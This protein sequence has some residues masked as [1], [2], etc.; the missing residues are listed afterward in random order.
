MHKIQG[1]IFVGHKVLHSIVWEELSKFTAQLSRQGFIVRQDERRTV[2]I[3]D[4]IRHREG[5]PTR[6]SSDLFRRLPSV[7]QSLPAGLR[8]AHKGQPIRN[9]PQQKPP[10]FR[11]YYSS[12]RIK[13]RQHA[14]SVSTQKSLKMSVDEFS[15]FSP[16]HELRELRGELRE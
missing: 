11:I 5:F 6:R 16:A 15:Y 9:D 14:Y 3:G 7:L 4:D 10:F 2:Y 1:K 12:Y 13:K 8:S